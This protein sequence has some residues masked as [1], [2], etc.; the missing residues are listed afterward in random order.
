MWTRRLLKVVVASS[1]LMGCQSQVNSHLL[2]EEDDPTSPDLV[3]SF[4]GDHVIE[5]G[6]IKFQLKFENKGLA[7]E[8]EVSVG[9]KAFLVPRGEYNR[10]L[11]GTGLVLE[12][13]YSPMNLGAGDEI[14][15]DVE[16]TLPNVPEGSYMLGATTNTRA[17]A[18][19][20]DGFD[21][22]FDDF[23]DD[24][25]FLQDEVQFVPETMAA[26]LNNATAKLLDLGDVVN[27]VEETEVRG[28]YDLYHEIQNASIGLDGGTAGHSSRNILRVME[29]EDEIPPYETWDHTISARFLFINLADETMSI[30]Q[31]TGSSVDKVWYAISWNAE[32]DAQGRD[33]HVDYYH[34]APRITH[35]QQGEYLLGVL[36]NVN[37]KFQLDSYPENNL[38][39]TYMNLEATS[40]INVPSETWLQVGGDQS[41]SYLS[42]NIGD[43]A[44]LHEWS[45]EIVDAPEWLN[46][47][48]DLDDYQYSLVLSTNAVAVPVGI[49]EL[50]LRIS[51]EGESETL[52]SETKLI[53]YKNEGP[54]LAVDG[55]RDEGQITLDDPNATLEEVDGIMVFKYKFDVV[56]AGTQP[57]I[58]SMNGQGAVTLE[59]P[60]NRIVQP[61]ER[62]TIYL[63][64]PMV[65]VAI[66]RE[67][68]GGGRTQYIYFNANSNG[69]NRSF[70]MYLNLSEG[71]DNDGDDDSD[72]ID[73][74]DGDDI[75][76][77]PVVFP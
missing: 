73:T 24:D 70:Y 57:L 22:D 72:E 71:D 6:K 26:Q 47:E 28:K 43:R 7:M 8:N 20:G 31:Y 46:V 74:G 32:A 60:E 52:V 2:D 76:L 66:P 14:I 62:Q 17:S 33:I 1:L 51:A 77:E 19:E 35:L 12:T 25:F 64:M 3:V 75:V 41:S 65:G 38:D 59:Q 36:M 5:D 39:L 21:D 27:V 10:K 56:N 34:N 67:G 37:D 61:G 69:G 42:A 44:D 15:V 13:I 30:G 23:D 40:Q 58:Y 16:K 54:I 49:H 55:L 11:V 63:T 68:E 53:V 29:G 48:T 18:G 4:V 50:T 45:Y 9:T